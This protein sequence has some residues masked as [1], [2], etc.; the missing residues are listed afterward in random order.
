[1]K[2]NIV[3]TAIMFCVVTMGIGCKKFLNVNH[4]PNNPTS[5]SESLQLG[6]IEKTTSGDIVGGFAGT[7]TAYWMQ[8]LSINQPSPDAENYEIFP[9]DVDNTWSF[10]LYPAIFENLKVM[11]AQAE[12]AQHYQYAAIGKTLF[13]YNLAI[14]TDLWNDIPYSEALNVDSTKPK[15][16]SQESIYNSI[17]SLLD[18]ALY[19][20]N[21]T[22]SAVAPG[23][24][25]FIY[26]GDMSE[27]QKFIYTLKA[28][29]YLRLTKAPGRT[30]SL[31]ADSALAALQ[32][33]FASNNDNAAV[34]YTGSSNDENPWYANTLPGAGGVVMAASFMD[35]LIARNDPR[36][37]VIA[38]PGSGGNYSGRQTGADPDPDYTIYSTV[39]TFYGGSLPLDPNNTAG[40]SAP[41]FLATYSEAL[42][43]EAEATFIKQGASAAQPIYDSAI[44]SHMSLLGI[45]TAAQAA[46]IASRPLLT[47]S[48]AIQQIITEK[49]VAD[50]LSLET[51]NDWRRTGFPVLTLAQNPYVNFIPRRWPYSSTE[52][53][54]NP[55]PQQSATIADR[56]WWDAQ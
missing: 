39:N 25:D 48:N 43:I 19:Y 26:G 27:W 49:Y 40:A 7:T 16:D 42:F 32:N 24:D 30:A 46:Y 6:P 15:Y 45:G 17:Q 4:N 12:S 37:P 9:A 55:Q 10:Y 8:Q 47:V 20:T 22:P 38:A 28:R 1:M 50:F 18:S 29:F 14:T 56:V 44:A 35:S 23:N 54:T 31:Q 21:Q 33:A 36:L 51:Y 52:I 3:I 53:L 41:L 5:V 2:K 34:A 11:I 13:A